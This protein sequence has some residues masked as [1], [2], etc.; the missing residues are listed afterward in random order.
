LNAV[1]RLDSVVLSMITPWFQRLQ[2]VL[3]EMGERKT[4]GKRKGGRKAQKED[5]EK[6]KFELILPTCGKLTVSRYAF[7]C[8]VVSPEY[9]GR[10]KLPSNLMV[11]IEV[12][13]SVILIYVT[14]MSGFPY[15]NTNL[16]PC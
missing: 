4:S 1:D 9:P 13:Q 15:T 8:F 12:R 16:F 11:S 10:H 3:K 14:K 2:E 7:L 5:G 6:D